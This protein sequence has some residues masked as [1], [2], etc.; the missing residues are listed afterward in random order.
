MAAIRFTD[1]DRDERGFVKV[2]AP[3]PVSQEPRS[4]ADLLP[5]PQSIQTD[6][7]RRPTS[8][9]EQAMLLVAAAGLAIVLAVWLGRGGAGIPAAPQ[10]SPAAPQSG[11]DVT[12]TPSP[13]A[14]AV[15]AVMLPAF[16]APDG[17]RLGEIEST[18]AI[19]PTAHYGDAWIQADVQGSGRVWLRV[20]DFPSLT[21]T[22]P[23]L[24]PR[25]TAT[26]RPYVP[27]TPEPQPPCAS[28]GVPGKMVEVCGW[29]DLAAEA[30]AKWLVTYG[31]SPGIVTTPTPQEW[32]KP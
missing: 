29:G 26:P 1:D 11:G 8:K 21:I 6:A 19:T 20:S 24:A 15:P 16:A 9:G 7:Q 5:T 27:P 30:Q 22:G 13:T 18:R 2:P 4:L 28:A 3:A 10:S 25:P 12:A 32:N 17:A 31:G 14:P 23:D